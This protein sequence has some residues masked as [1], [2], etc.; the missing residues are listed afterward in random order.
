M[1]ASTLNIEIEQGV[2]FRL[3]LTL[4]DALDDLIDLTTYTLRGHARIEH[5]S[6]DKAFE[7][8]F[9]KSNQMTNMGEVQMSLGHT[10]SSALN[11][12]L[13][14]VVNGLYKLV[15]DVEL[16]AASGE[17]SRLM[18]GTVSISPEVTK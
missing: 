16:V 5:K 18:S 10:T 13:F 17:P 3:D 11:L 1:A 15:Y 8:V 12:T 9:T 2:S 4:R 6:R 14:P 7:F